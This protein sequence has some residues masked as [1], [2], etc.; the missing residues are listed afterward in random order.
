M[1][2]VPLSVH[3]RLK[4]GEVPL[5]YMVIETPLGSRA[6]AEKE[7]PAA[8]SVSGNRGDG[9]VPGDG[10]VLGGSDAIPM[11]EKSGRVLSYGAYERTIQPRKD[12]VLTAYTGK[13][14]QHITI[15]LDNADG[16]FSRL[17]P[18][19]PFLGRPISLYVAFEAEPQTT[20]M[21]RFGGIISELSM[22]EKMTIEADER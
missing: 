22:M 19:E 16:Y 14:L 7:L 8:F 15:T 6:Y 13:Q 2:R 9:T 12:D 1:Y 20:R 10:T 3:K 18:K 11:L 21:K 4:R 17:I 5:V